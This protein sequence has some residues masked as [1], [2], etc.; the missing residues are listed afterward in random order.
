MRETS[1]RS[2]AFTASMTLIPGLSV[3]FLLLGIGAPLFAFVAP[4]PCAGWMGPSGCPARDRALAWAWPSFVA[5]VVSAVALA[6]VANLAV[7]KPQVTRGHREAFLVSGTTLSVMVVTANVSLLGGYTPLTIP[8][9][10]AVAVAM[11]TVIALARQDL[12]SHPAAA[13]RRVK[14]A[15][16]IFGL[17]VAI[18]LAGAIAIPYWPSTLPVLLWVV[19][20]VAT[21]AIPLVLYS[22]LRASLRY[23]IRPLYR[24]FVRGALE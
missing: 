1:E 20:F 5:G 22:Y 3:V 13:R 10:L 18:I 17:Q 12:S 6:F 2:P 11:T 23:G 4:E 15:C 9:I 21:F 14:V 19:Y 24:R 7:R 16:T 8:G